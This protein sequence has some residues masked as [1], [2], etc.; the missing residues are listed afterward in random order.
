MSESSL[1]PIV[2]AGEVFFSVEPATII[3]FKSFGQEIE[4]FKN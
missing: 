3:Q 1:T 2:S 4:K